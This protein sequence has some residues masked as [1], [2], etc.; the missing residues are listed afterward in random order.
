MTSGPRIRTDIVDVYVFRTGDTPDDIDFLQLRRTRPP[1]RAD[2][3]PVM[4]HTRDGESALDC[5]LRELREEVGLDARS[6]AARGLWQLEQVHPF[7]L[8]ERN[9]IILSPR[10]AVRVGASWTP[11][12]NDEHDAHRWASLEDL[13][14]LFRW[15]GQRACCR[16]IAEEIVARGAYEP[17]LS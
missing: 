13:E 15:P 7:F 4:G 16:E 17:L 6:D 2:W 3:H 8:A 11:I 14:A 10:F 1:M 9:E 5:V 12:L